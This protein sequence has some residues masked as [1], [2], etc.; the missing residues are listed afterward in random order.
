[1]YTSTAAI[2]DVIDLGVPGFT[3][4][5]RRRTATDAQKRI[6]DQ[7]GGPS[8]SDRFK[9]RGRFTSM[10]EHEPFTLSDAAQ[11]ALGIPAEFEHSHSPHDR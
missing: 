3:S 8:R 11:N 1:M 5:A 2:K 9:T 6:V 4:R 7:A 10:R